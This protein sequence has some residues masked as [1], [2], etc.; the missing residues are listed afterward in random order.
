MKKIREESTHIKVKVVT[1]KI[2]SFVQLNYI[3]E[4]KNL[5]PHSFH[6]YNDSDNDK[7]F[8]ST[9]HNTIIIQLLMPKYWITR[10]NVKTKICR[11][12]TLPPHIHDNYI[13]CT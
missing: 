3:L 11:W 7:I 8:Y 12:H 4:M 9:P 1:M 5:Q 6:I 2:E 10:Q 13:Y